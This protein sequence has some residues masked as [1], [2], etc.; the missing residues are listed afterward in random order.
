MTHNK[1]SAYYVEIFLGGDSSI[2]STNTNGIIRHYVFCYFVCSLVSEQRQLNVFT[3]T[4]VNDEI[5]LICENFD[6][7]RIESALFLT[8]L[9]Q[10]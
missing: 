8:R 5:S 6:Q 4:K 7:N 3:K 2:K 1:W 9:C 10:C